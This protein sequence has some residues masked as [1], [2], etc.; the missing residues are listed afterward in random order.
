MELSKIFKNRKTL[1]YILIGIAVFFILVFLGIIPGL[2][3]DNGGGGDGE[4]SLKFWGTEPSEY[5]SDLISN[6]QSLHSNVKIEYKEISEANYEDTIINALAGQNG[7]DIFLIKNNWVLKHF[8]KLSPIPSTWLTVSQLKDGFPDVVAQ[9]MVY[10]GKIWGLPLWIDTL[11]LYYNKDIFNSANI[12]F[13]PTTWQEFQE[14]VRSLTQNS[15]SYDI[16]Q[17]GTAMG[18]SANIDNSSDI[19]SA[20]MIQAGSSISDS[21]GQVDFNSDAVKQALSFY[22][23][24]SNPSSL[25]YSWNNNM[26]N[27]LEAFAQG[28][29]AMVIDYSSARQ[30]I[31][32][33]NPY[34][35]YGI[36][37]FPQSVKNASVLKYYAK[38][39]SLA[40]AGSSQN[41]DA[42]WSFIFYLVNAD[43]ARQY[44]E[45][46]D[47]PPSSRILVKEMSNDED[48][49][50]FT[51][52]VLSAKSWVQVYP[53]E[54]S[55][56]IKNMIQLV[57][58]GK[59]TVENALRQAQDE[60][61]NLINK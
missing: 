12:A 42:S 5:Y 33:Q 56:I 47:L 10:Q 1:L 59:S 53:E 28:K 15:L 44:L 13:A 16:T 52:Q 20:L 29:V 38:Y 25:Y 40:V 57:V 21:E 60:I 19:L 49:G 11:A 39:W 46:A 34:L 31:E 50:V 27:S 26:P 4:I 24:F 55:D 14:A 51:K 3:K 37:S 30:K 6:Y 23:S 43:Q 58:N 45:K 18:T 22:T 32:E 8:D 41:S 7:P 36:G 17:A 48:L 9:D 35:N 61:N 54:N 2:K